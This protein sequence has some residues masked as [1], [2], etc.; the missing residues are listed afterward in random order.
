[1]VSD[2]LGA[3]VPEKE[4]VDV[5]DALDFPFE[6]TDILAKTLIRLKKLDQPTQE[7]SSIGLCD[8]RCLDQKVFR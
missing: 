8:L 1:M 7:K 3:L 2:A 4:K 5:K 6:M